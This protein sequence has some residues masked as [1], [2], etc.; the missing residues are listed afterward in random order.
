VQ[1]NRACVDETLQL[2]CDVAIS[3]TGTRKYPFG[4]I[5]NESIILY[6]SLKTH[7]KYSVVAIADFV[8]YVVI[9]GISK[10]LYYE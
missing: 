10:G 9:V 2:Y 7:V 3:T 5:D 1:Q 8:L 6:K 4:G